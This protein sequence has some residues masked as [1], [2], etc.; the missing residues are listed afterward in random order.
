MFRL[1]IGLEHGFA[2]FGAAIVTTLLLTRALTGS[3][4]PAVTRSAFMAL[5]MLYFLNVE[6]VCTNV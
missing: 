6:F 2:E 3:V 5:H 1:C 4:R